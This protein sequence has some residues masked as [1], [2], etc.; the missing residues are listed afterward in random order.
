MSNKLVVIINSL[1]VPKIKKILLYGIKF[2]VPNYS[3]LQNPWLGGYAPRSPFSLSSV[4][5]WIC[6]TPPAE[7]KFLG[8][9]LVHSDRCSN[10]D[11]QN[12]K[13]KEVEEKLKYHSLCTEIKR[14][15]NMKC[16]IA[17]LMTEDNGRV[18]RGLK[19]LEA[20]PGKHNRYT[21]KDSYI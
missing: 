7:K 12:V 21:A 18:T 8:T 16:M 13:Q 17:P 11:G 3:S 20:T 19:N 9:P 5:N 6:W 2:L 14:T 1:K 10:T 4:L 15:W